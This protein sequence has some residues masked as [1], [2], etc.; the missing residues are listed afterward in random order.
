M[1]PVPASPRTSFHYVAHCTNL[2][3]VAANPHV[4]PEFCPPPPLPTAA[5]PFPCP[6]PHHPCAMPLRCLLVT[7]ISVGEEE[8][9]EPAMA[10]AYLLLSLPSLEK[11]AME[12]LDWA[13]TCM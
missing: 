8:E 6:P 11:V 13:P 3:L 7:D 1:V 2:S 10:A 4:T 9:G 12:G 5:I